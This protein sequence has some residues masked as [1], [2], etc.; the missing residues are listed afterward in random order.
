MLELKQVFTPMNVGPVTIPNRFVVP[1]MVTN[2]CD[3]NNCITE[4][5]IKYMEEKAIG[6]FGLLITEDYAV[7]P[8][9]RGYA[10]IPGLYNDE[11]VKGN[12]KLTEAVHKH[13]AK[14]F[15]QMYHPGKQATMA[16]NGGVTPIAPSAIKD[17]LCLTQP[18]EITVEEIHQLVKDFGSA[19][20]RAEQAGFDGVEIHAGHG[21]LI[22][23]FLSPFI[24]KR[25]DEYGGCFDNRVRFLDEI[26]AEVRKNVSKDFAVQVRFSPNEYVVGGRTETEAYVLA[27][28][29]D[30]LGVD[31]LNVS[32][33]AYASDMIHQ[34]IAPMFTDHALNADTAAQIKKLVSCP[35]MVANRINDPN[36]A[37]NIIRMGK[38]DFV[39]MGRGSICDPHLPNK[40]RAGQFDQI[41]YCIGC[42]QGCVQ[43]FNDGGT[44]TYTCLV[45]PRVGREFENDM[46]P[47]EN[48][49]KVMVIG[50]G[51]AGLIAAK[52][53]AQRGHQVTVFE[54]E[55]YVGG[56]FRAAAYPMGKGEL[57]TVPASLWASVKALGVEVKLGTEAD[58]TLIQ[59]E[60]PDA[61]I[62]ATGSRPL[63]P[64]IEGIDS[65]NVVTAEDVLY[66]NVDINPFAPVVVCGGGEVGGE[67]AEFIAESAFNVTILEMQP[68]I[69][70][71]MVFQNKAILMELLAK[72]NVRII[73]D[74][75][76][77]K[78]TESGVKY[79]DASSNEVE[80]PAAVVVSAFGYKAYN[81]LEETAR[82]N[83]C[84]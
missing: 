74:A 16:A 10:R 32:N 34:V 45:N 29:L 53:A 65:A 77:S 63:M 84:G 23:E 82:K 54:K 59:S 12:K 40:A 30:D 73:T 20:K 1:T 83:N 15:C 24:N 56:A 79:T 75:K 44:G 80:L 70:N 64:P 36:M 72:K 58:E 14:I 4:R 27:Q 28:H 76:V 42:L 61:I 41:H 67:T 48:P 18:R 7:E 46:S 51:P 50:A 26:Y 5:Y 37:E 22:A 11:Q 60:K 66:G 68:A 71:D 3:D 62:V 38:A 17:P 57:S 47:V 69:L 19:A 2:Y 6:G 55:P 52:T 78:I 13:G 31:A 9:G 25:T 35:V 21:Y 49:K 43:I 81:P 8:H 39:D 33:G